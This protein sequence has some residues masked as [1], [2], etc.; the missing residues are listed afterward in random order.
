MRMEEMRVGMEREWRE[1]E[2]RDEGESER[3]KPHSFI[4]RE[5]YNI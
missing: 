3:V 2:V 4:S 5:S 1:K